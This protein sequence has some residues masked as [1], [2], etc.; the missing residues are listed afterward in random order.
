M[1]I[2]LV[3]S[4]DS[5]THDL[6]CPP[7]PWLGKPRL[8]DDFS[9][10][11]VLDICMIYVAFICTV[12]RPLIPHDTSCFLGAPLFYADEN[13]AWGIKDSSKYI[14]DMKNVIHRTGFIQRLNMMKMINNASSP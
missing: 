14:Q 10:Y 11:V 1:M 7:T 8:L 13:K 5:C 2:A 9:F 12:L 4:I 6:C 3:L